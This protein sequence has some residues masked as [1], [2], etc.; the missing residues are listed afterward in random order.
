M[1]L[2]PDVVPDSKDEA[3]PSAVVFNFVLERLAGKDEEVS[4]RL[5]M[6]FSEEGSETIVFV[7]LCFLSVLE[8]RF[9]IHS[10]V[11]RVMDNDNQEVEHDNF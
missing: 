2:L 1:D 4:V 10:G 8:L 5:V 9:V 6:D 11:V 3:V 7:E